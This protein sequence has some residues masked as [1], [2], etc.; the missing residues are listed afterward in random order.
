M[1]QVATVGEAGWRGMT[2]MQ[3]ITLARQTDVLIGPSG[4]E[5]GL[6]AFM[7]PRKWL[8]ELMPPAVRPHISSTAPVHEYINCKEKWD[9]NPGSLVG[10]TAY[11][12]N[13][14]HF[15]V[16]VQNPGNRLYTSSELESPHWRF[17]PSL[18]VSAI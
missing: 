9:A 10:H 6:A 18:Y 15:C 3:Q 8:I 11:R 4:N 2:A 7:Q 1:G 5:L 12:A 13:I 16:G 17:S 14:H